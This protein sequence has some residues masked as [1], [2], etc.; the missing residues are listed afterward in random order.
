MVLFGSSVFDSIDSV[1]FSSFGSVLFYGLCCVGIS[2]NVFQHSVIDTS[3]LSA[4]EGSLRLLS[5]HPR[6]VP[7]SQR[8]GVHPGRY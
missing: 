5:L 4:A 1:Q 3:L 2:V 8:G 7:L 6:R